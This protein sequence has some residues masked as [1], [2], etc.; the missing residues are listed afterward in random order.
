LP[1]GEAYFQRVSSESNVDIMEQIAH[2]GYVVKNID[3]SIKGW[4]SSGYTVTIPETFD[5]IQNVNCLLL[6]KVGEP[7]IELVSPGDKGDHPLNARLNRGGGLDHICF[8]TES[9]EDAIRIEKASGSIVVCEPVPAI[10]FKSRIA[11]V[12][13]R[14]GILIEYLEREL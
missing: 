4:L 3:L 6:S 9:I 5:P 12:L 1:K 13:R 2:I 7:S 11:F 8:Y 14:S 10:T